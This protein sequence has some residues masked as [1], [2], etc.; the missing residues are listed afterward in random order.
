MGHKWGSLAIIPRKPI[1]V[2]S[3]GYEAMR[4]TSTEN[5]DLRKMHSKFGETM[6][7]GK[8]QMTPTHHSESMPA[9]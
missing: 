1:W 3:R 7:S 6:N 2:I 5:G 8:N 9:P 4:W